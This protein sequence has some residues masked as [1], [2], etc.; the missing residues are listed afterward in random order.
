MF[1]EED[2]LKL[3]RNNFDGNLPQWICEL[4][5]LR[6][7]HLRYNLF[8]GAIPECIGSLIVLRDLNLSD[9]EL[10]GELPIGICDLVKLEELYIFYTKVEGNDFFNTQGSIPECIGSLN[11]LGHLDLKRNKLTGELPIGI[12]KLV[13][14]E[15][16]SLN[17][18]MIEGIIASPY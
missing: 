12:C 9:N 6:L 18:N 2:N 7:L 13:K 10:N 5:A 17:D 15:Q 8:T 4:T 3:Q 16:F 11:L 14:L 1:N